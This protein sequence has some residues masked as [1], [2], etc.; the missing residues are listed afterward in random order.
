MRNREREENQAQLIHQGKMASLGEMAAELA[1]EI[2]NPANYIYGNI[3]FLEKYIKDIKSILL[4]YM[5]LELPDGHQINQ[6][7]KDL[8]I[9][10]EVKELDGLI[11]YVKEGAIRISDTVDNLM[12]FVGKEESEIQSIDIHESIEITLNLIQNKIKKR[13]EVKKIF[14]EIPEIEGY[15]WQINQVW[16]NLLSNAADAIPGQ[17]VITI[18][19]SMNDAYNV[20]IRITDTG[21]GIPEANLDRIFEPFYSTKLKR[22][23]MGL[24]LTITKKIIEKHNGKIECESKEG[25]GTCFSII[26]PIN[27][28]EEK[29]ND[30]KPN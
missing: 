4:E 19:T 16:M 1:H 3:D 2:N 21:V 29:Q 20:F 17:G 26:L 12:N 23:G 15:P 22:R 5:Q 18:E 6:I 10:E 24:G 7:R 13:V 11:K 30:A 27:Q 25:Q 28:K 14:G 9:E 8:Y